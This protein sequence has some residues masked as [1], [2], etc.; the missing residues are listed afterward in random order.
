MGELLVGEKEPEEFVDPFMGNLMKDPVKLTTSGRVVDRSVA[1]Q[2][3]LRGGRDPFNNERLTTAHLEAQPELQARIRQFLEKKSAWD[4]RVELKE[5]APLVE[6]SQVDADL[7]EALLEVEQI[8]NALKKT[9]I[10]ARASSRTAG[11]GLESDGD[12]ADVEA[13]EEEEA[14]AADEGATDVDPETAAINAMLDSFPDASHDLAAVLG[15][16]N[17]GPAR[18]AEKAGIVQV[19]DKTGT[20][21]MHI[22]GAGVKAFHYSTVHQP[23]ASQEQVYEKDAQDAISA[24]LHGLNACIMCYGQTGAGKT[25]T[26][27]GPDGTLEA[28]NDSSEQEA[29]HGI[30]IR[31]CQELLQARDFLCKNGVNVSFTAQFVEI[32]EEQVTDLLTGQRVSVRRDNGHINGA[33]EA[34][35]NTMQQVMETLRCGHERKRFAAT[36]MNERSSRS[37]TAFVVHVL[38][39]LD[40]G[41]MGQF[42]RSGASGLCAAL[43]GAVSDKLIRSQLHLIDLAGSERVK[44][45]KAEGVRLREAVGINSSLLVLGKVISSLVQGN[46]HVPYFESKL[47]TLLKAAFGGN[48]KTTV[49]INCRSDGDYGD[50]TLQSMRFGERCAMISN[51]LRQAASSFETAIGAVEEALAAVRAQLVS[52]EARG[53]QHLPSYKNLLASCNTLDR[54][55]K[56]LVAINESKR[57]KEEEPL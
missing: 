55:R 57:E 1:V 50:E 5:L 37:H 35:I 33:V 21:C 13:E 39:K 20:V 9:E 11:A 44:K 41:K 42:A 22:P 47:T 54:K 36:A 48:S 12:A 31:A 6:E 45:S 27:F 53:K 43:G 28:K 38:Q 15:D 52:L 32:Y 29:K 4:V 17:E 18:K 51:S 23:E 10:E 49:V 24:V 46:S 30:V 14:D 19:D 40:P 34:P 2:C 16:R 26:F 8:N 25:Y 56:E 7:L 3:I